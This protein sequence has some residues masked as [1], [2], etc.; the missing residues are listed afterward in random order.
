MLEW[1]E[2]DLKSFDSNF[3]KMPASI[4]W[5]M[6]VVFL[7]GKAYHHGLY[8]TAI[9]ANADNLVKGL[10]SAMAKAGA[11]SRAIGKAF[12]VMGTGITDAWMVNRDTG[13]SYALTN[14]GEWDYDN[15]F[16]SMAALLDHHTNVNAQ[17]RFFINEQVA[18]PSFEYSIVLT[19]L[20]SRF[21]TS[22]VW[23]CG[24]MRVA[25]WPVSIVT[26]LAVPKSST[27]RTNILSRSGATPPRK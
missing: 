19:R 5:R 20:V 26:L 16:T 7:K 8:G 18:S 27:F 3:S 4:F 10:K 9:K 21:T 23:A 6:A 24:S 2:K 17:Y 15:Q 1:L 11:A 14:G 12:T 22:T 13:R 25:R